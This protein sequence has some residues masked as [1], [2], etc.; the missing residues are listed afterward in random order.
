M[1]RHA[2]LITLGLWFA[3]CGRPEPKP[4]SVLSLGEFD[5]APHTEATWCANMKSPLPKDIQVTRLDIDMAKGS[6]HFVLLEVLGDRA[7]DFWECSKGNGLMPGIPIFAAQ[8]PYERFDYPTAVAHKVRA[9]QQFA[10]QLHVVNTGEQQ[11][12]AF[13]KVSLYAGDP[14]KIQFQDGI[15]GFNND[16]LKLPPGAELSF[17][18][19]C[20]IAVPA[21]VFSLSSHAHKQLLDFTARPFGP[22]RIVGDEVYRSTVWSD[23]VV[24][25]FPDRQPLALASGGGL[26]FTCHDR[27]PT[28][29]TITVG[30]SAETDEMCIVFGHYYPGP[31]LLFCL[32]DKEQIPTCPAG[33]I[34]AKDCTFGPE[35]CQQSQCPEFNACILN[36]GLSSGCFQ[37]CQTSISDRCE[38]CIM[39]LA[40]CAFANGCISTGGLNFK[41]LTDHCAAQ[42]K[43][44]FGM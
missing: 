21:N 1:N 10:M 8:H 4:D 27:N 39:P 17:T 5:V 31:G 6:H 28:D 2:V 35:M 43:Q 36:C 32:D 14:K 26:E 3:G 11:I 24:E 22:D 25:N 40:S 42:R 23:P 38:S 41:C 30:S 7:D 19:Q 34:T 37:C 18:R 12:H 16:A 20:R 29:R 15:I 33:P 9:Q 44:C 13:A